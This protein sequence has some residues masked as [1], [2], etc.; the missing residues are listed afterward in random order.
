MRLTNTH[1]FRHGRT[2][3]ARPARIWSFLTVHELAERITILGQAV[4]FFVFKLREQQRS[5][6]SAIGGSRSDSWSSSGGNCTNSGNSGIGSSS[7]SGGSGGSGGSGTGSGRATRVLL[8]LLAA[9]A[10]HRLE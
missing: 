8:Q 5:T 3:P 9:V 6:R 1:A 10:S 7:A 4:A 2:T